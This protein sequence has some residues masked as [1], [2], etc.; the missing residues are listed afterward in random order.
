MLQT[1]QNNEPA[2]M[3][4]RLEAKEE[5]AEALKY[6]KKALAADSKSEQAKEKTATLSAVIEKQVCQI[7]HDV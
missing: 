1:L 7:S 2:V 5:L 3:F 4:Y 6:Y